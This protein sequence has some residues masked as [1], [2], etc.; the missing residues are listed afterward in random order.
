MKLENNLALCSLKQNY[1]NYQTFILRETERESERKRDRDRELTHLMSLHSAVESELLPG[2]GHQPG[3]VEVLVQEG[4]GELM[5][6]SGGL[7]AAKSR[8]LQINLI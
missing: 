4:R 3:V 7:D 8:N 5:V 2:A 1:D 6:F